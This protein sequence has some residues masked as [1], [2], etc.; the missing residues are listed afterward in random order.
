MTNMGYDGHGE[1]HPGAI[2]ERGPSTPWNDDYEFPH[3]AGPPEEQQTDE[4]Y[5]Q[6]EER[7]LNKR[8]A[9]MYSVVKNKLAKNPDTPLYLSDMTQRNNQKQVSLFVFSWL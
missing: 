6:F 8:A 4:T 5:E 9:H 3:S 2:S 7:V 1:H